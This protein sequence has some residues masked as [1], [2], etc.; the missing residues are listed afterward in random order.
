LGHGFEK[1][2]MLRHAWWKGFRAA[3]SSEGYGV[4]LLGPKFGVEYREG[5]HVIRI[6]VE[7]FTVDAD[8]VTYMPSKIDW[9]PP[10][11]HE[12]VSEEKRQQVR[13]RV[14]ES[15][16]FLKIKYYLSD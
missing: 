12:P 14:I 11:Q 5:D 4:N 8:W 7:R 16:D 3:R 15:L 1:A 2:G 6:G 13:E 10:Y 9:L